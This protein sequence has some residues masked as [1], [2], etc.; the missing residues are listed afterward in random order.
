[1]KVHENDVVLGEKCP[2]I[3]LS[4]ITTLEDGCFLGNE[5]YDSA[6]YARAHLQVEIPPFGESRVRLRETTTATQFDGAL[7][8]FDMG[9][10]YDT[11]QNN[12]YSRVGN[13]V[14]S[15]MRKQ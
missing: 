3:V 6:V 12:H 13:F 9:W 8:Q 5:A 1:M 2:F 14:T 4:N 15:M 7:R 10:Q 11:E